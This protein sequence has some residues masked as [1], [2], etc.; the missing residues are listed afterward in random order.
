MELKHA[1]GTM[2]TLAMGVAACLALSG[3]ESEL[4]KAQ[5]N[6]AQ[7]ADLLPGRY[8]NGA[9]ADADAKRGREKHEPKSI[10][11]VRLDLPLLSDYAFYAQENSLEQMGH[12]VS[13]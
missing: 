11:I 2:M 5:V 6:V 10:D 9:Q 1:A 8:T 12:I 7:I 13:Q 4:K 3:C